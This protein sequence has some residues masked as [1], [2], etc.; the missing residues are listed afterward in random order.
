VGKT[1]PWCPMVFLLFFKNTDLGWNY[2]FNH[3][4]IIII[5]LS[6]QTYIF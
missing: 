6:H 4:L 2:N 3:I 5:F 1:N